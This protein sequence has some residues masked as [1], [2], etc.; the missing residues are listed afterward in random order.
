MND[1]SHVDCNCI[2]AGVLYAPLSVVLQ[3]QDDLTA[4][5]ETTVTRD[6]FSAVVS[7]LQWRL[8][9]MPAVMHVAHACASECAAHMFICCHGPHSP[10]PR[11]A[12]AGAHG[13][14][15]QNIL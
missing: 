7:N 3:V 2:V 9:T 8:I 1:H 11:H 13:Q 14:G 12:P 10:T 6:A 5:R 15:T 4:I